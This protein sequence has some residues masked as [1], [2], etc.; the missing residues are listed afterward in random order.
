[1]IE[2]SREPKLRPEDSSKYQELRKKMVNEQIRSRGIVN[3]L[4]L[5][6]ME[7]VPRHRFV[8]ESLEGS[9]YDDTPLSIGESQTISQPYIVACMSADLELKGG[10]KVLEIGAGSGYQAAVL[11]EIAAKVYTIE[12]N[13]NLTI[14]VSRRLKKLGY[15]NVTIR[16]GD[17]Y[18]GLPEQAP[19]DGIMVTAAPDHI[20]QPLIDQLKVGGSMVIPVGGGET[21]ELFKVTKLSDGSIKKKSRIPVRFVPMI[22]KAEKKD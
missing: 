20:P 9:A 13:E 19:F 10:E 4:V 11:S 3:P 18:K 2:I 1:M 5:A 17:G 6:A 14:E 16:F 21:Q 12:I 22:G 7:R 8:D 15:L